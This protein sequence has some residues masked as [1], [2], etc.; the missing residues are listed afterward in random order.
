M[1]WVCAVQRCVCLC[2]SVCVS[3]TFVCIFSSVLVG[4]SISHSLSLSNFQ[5]RKTHVSWTFRLFF[6]CPLHHTTHTSP[7]SPRL[8]IVLSCCFVLFSPRSI[9]CFPPF[10]LFVFN[11][12]LAPELIISPILCNSHFFVASIHHPRRCIVSTLPLAP[13]HPSASW[14]FHFGSLYDL[15]VSF[16]FS[17]AWQP[18]IR[19]TLASIPSSHLPLLYWSH[20]NI[21]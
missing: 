18:H 10:H 20:R 21:C 15:G 2:G 7:R 6:S 16:R 17:A 11:P 19:K 13:L 1:K 5:Y 8:S 12:A 9:H 3:A 4:S 14:H